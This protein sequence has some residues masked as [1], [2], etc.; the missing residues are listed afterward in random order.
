MEV[1]GKEFIR[2]IGIEQD[3]E[4]LYQEHARLEAEKRES[5]KRS[6]NYF[7]D[8][9]D[10]IDKKSDD[11]SK[12]SNLN[13]EESAY[14]DLSIDNN[15]EANIGKE[16][17]QDMFADQ[18]IEAKNKKKY[19]ILGLGLIILF[20]ITIL[21]IRLISNN[22]TQQQLLKSETT[23]L[24]KDKILNKI[25]TNE[26]YQKVIDKKVAHEESQ[27][28]SKS[29]A[30]ELNEVVLPQESE[31]V[32]MVIDT[33]KPKAPPQRDLFGLEKTQKPKEQVVEPPKTIQ[34]KEE[35]A[36]KVEKKPVQK[37]QRKIVVPPA[38][39]KDFTKN[40]KK[41][42]GYFIQIGAF[43]K[44]PSNKLLNSIAKK[45]YNYRIHAMNIKGRIYNK[46]L[47]GSYAT[48]AQASK[49]LKRVRKDFNNPSAYILRF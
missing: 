29:Q 44:Q 30:K 14:V 47:I 41:I 13:E 26:E 45:G 25:D 2:N 8:D 23:V 42:S 35:V 43:T 17:L 33:P 19:I 39:E 48:K 34:K 12:N 49:D 9:Y 27:R 10:E 38:V 1:N 7:D 3:K 28:I 16:K 21:V 18:S 31:K 15:P 37:I 4:R 24:Q 46:V 36:P 11:N 6:P 22:D 5:V 32:P 40:T 20:I